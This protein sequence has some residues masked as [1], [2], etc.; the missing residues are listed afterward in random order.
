MDYSK[1]SREQLIEII[2]ELSMLNKE[3]LAEKEMEVKLNFAWAGNLGNWYFNVKTGA[4]VFNPLKV[5]AL[6]YTME[7]LPEKVNYTFFTDKL[8]PEDYRKAM[9]AML[10]NMQGKTNVYEVEYRIQA[11]D[12]SWKWFYDR[13][14]VTQ[15]DA[16]G[17]PEFAAG[18]VFDITEQKEQELQLK[19]N[20][21]ILSKVSVTDE[22]TRIRNRRAIMEELENRMD[23][24]LKN[25]S[26]LSIAMLDIDKFKILNDTKGHTF[27]DTVIKEVAKIATG[28]IRGLDTIG[29]YGGEE[30]LAIF[31]N[32]NKENALLVCE[33]IRKHV[34]EYDFGEGCKVTI[35]GGVACYSRE[36]IIEFIDKA[37]KKLYEAKSNGRN[38]VES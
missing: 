19:E 18:I 36:G 15:R 5:M 31:P 37:D 29:R 11:K 33:R 17:K 9:E 27:G 12:K 16:G 26:P 1:Y 24:A 3:L 28:S 32:T 21:Q 30:F 20:N 4:V 25:R 6:G 14:K 23:E 34:E 35:S 7:E 13:G 8:H 10:L 22:L 38:R 2:D